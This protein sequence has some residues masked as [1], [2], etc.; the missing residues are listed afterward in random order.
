[1]RGPIECEVEEPVVG[2]GSSRR[3]TECRRSR[4]RCRFSR[5]TGNGERREELRGGR[6]Y[7]N[8]G[9][10]QINFNIRNLVNDPDSAPKGLNWNA[11]AN[12]DELPEVFQDMMNPEAFDSDKENP[13]IE[14]QDRDQDAGSD[15]DS[16]SDSESKETDSDSDQGPDQMVFDTED[17]DSDLAEGGEDSGTEGVMRLLYAPS[18]S[19][20]ETPQSDG[21][22]FC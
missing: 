5:P 3:K 4:R 20:Q 22:V 16:G 21:V 2:L 17:M 12:N 10:K 14:D 9:K 19:P 15:S 1:M 7:Y 18:P 8:C 11:I 6:L 13:D